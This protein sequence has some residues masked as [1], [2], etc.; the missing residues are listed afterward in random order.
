VLSK[1]IDVPHL[2]D[3]ILAVARGETVISQAQSAIAGEIRLRAHEASP[4][5]TTAPPGA[6]SS[7]RRRRRCGATRRP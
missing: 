4:R 7:R 5:R 3:A 1:L 2:L 6:R